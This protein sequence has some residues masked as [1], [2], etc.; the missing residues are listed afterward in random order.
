V[1]DVG[2]VPVL[3]LDVLYSQVW[4]STGDHSAR[5]VSVA[6]HSFGAGVVRG[7]VVSLTLP[8]YV[9]GYLGSALARD[10]EFLSAAWGCHVG[11]ACDFGGG[12][13]FVDHGPSDGLSSLI[14]RVIFAGDDPDIAFWPIRDVVEEIPAVLRVTFVSVAIASGVDFP[15][16]VVDCS[17]G[18]VS[19][20]AV[21][22][23]RSC[24]LL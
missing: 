1:F 23:G 7:V 13:W 8:D 14:V 5:H 6:F 19:G 9:G 3:L 22:L 20:L 21:D 2:F 15:G 17:A 11:S 12:G 24:V 4:L 18:D 16:T 10:I